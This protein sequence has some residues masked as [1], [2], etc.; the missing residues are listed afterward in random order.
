MLL[1]RRAIPA[2]T[3]AAGLGLGTAY[4]VE[5]TARDEELPRQWDREA[6]ASYWRTRPLAASSRALEIASTLTLLAARLAADRAFVGPD[7]PAAEKAARQRFR[8]TQARDALVELG[9]AFIKLGQQLS[10]RPDVVPPPALEVLRSLCDAV[11]AVPT[12]VALETVRA[13][14]G[15]IQFEGLDEDAV[16]E[17]AA[18]LGQVYRARFE[19][20]DVAIKI[21]RPDMTTG[22]ARDLYL[23]GNWARFVEQVKSVFVPAQRPYDVQLIDAFCKGAYGEL[24]YE[25]EACN[26]RRFKDAVMNGPSSLRDVRVP[27]V[28]LATRRVLVTDWVAGERLSQ[29]PQA[30]IKQLV[31]LGV[32]LFCWQLLDLGFYHCD[33]HPGNL[34]VDAKGRLCVIDFGLCA[35]ISAPARESMTK[36]M[37]HLIEGKVAALVEDAV[38]LDFLPHDCD[39]DV[40][41]PLLARVFDGARLAAKAAD[42]AP[43]QKRRKEFAAVSSDLNSIF[44]EQPFRVPD[45][46]ALVTRALITL[47]GIALAGDPDFDIFKAAYPHGLRRARELFG[48]EGLARIA[49]AAARETVRAKRTEPLPV[50]RRRLT[51]V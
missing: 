19:G 42:G 10:I 35:E 49:A 45:Y 26:Q 9:P 25:Q 34:L 8:A 29:A 6:V 17:A 13:D 2:V 38:D 24:D 22:V 11:P 28:R 40:L 1:A 33:P 4:A 50:P 16:P 41:V 20:R 51:T 3:A 30:T 36:A 39:R 43:V 12:A 5:P 27:E 31:P 21:Q 23:L 18:S 7:E 14:L 32:E 46:F 44:F 48:V 37:V 15:A 47:E